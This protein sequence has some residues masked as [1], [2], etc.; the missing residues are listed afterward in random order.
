MNVKGF[1]FAAIPSRQK[2]WDRDDLALIFSER[3][4]VVAG[5]FTKNRF[6][7]A[8]VELSE[9]RVKTGKARA[10]LVNAGVANACT[11]PEGLEDARK[12]TEAAASALGIPADEVLTASTGVIGARL[13]MDGLLGALPQLVS[14]L[15][16]GSF[17]K[18]ARAIMTTDT[19]SKSSHAK[20]EIQGIP[21]SIAG[22]AKG[23]GMIRPDMATMLC[24]VLTDLNL[25][26]GLLEKIAKPAADRSFH[27]INVDGD[28]STNDTVLFLANGAGG[29]PLLQEDSDC[30]DEVAE[31]FTGVCLDLAKQI[32]MDAEGATKFIDIR[33]LG[34]ADESDAARAAHLISESKLVK[35]AFF[36]EDANWG[37][38]LAALG[39]SGASFSP[40]RVDLYFGETC[41]VKNG[42]Y[43]GKEAE[44]QASEA[45][46]HRN[47]VVKLDLKQGS[48]EYNVYTS[49]L[50]L[51]YVKINADYRS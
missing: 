28:T 10:V 3:E 40:E 11:G 32:V 34:A 25:S 50:S 42:R 31:A 45:L 16:P 46:K 48:A 17:S 4:A 23:A 47:I 24:F 26:R 6:K 19:V 27:R 30:V 51:D 5:L 35:T 22:V 29:G 9:E 1:R 39:R 12:A 13:N 8:P 33:I 38:I 36:G 15:D 20:G 18:V 49:D 44:A 21:Y 37:R 43:M 7:A 41:L 2:K 14:S